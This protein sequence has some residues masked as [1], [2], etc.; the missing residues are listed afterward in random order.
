MRVVPNCYPSLC[1]KDG[2]TGWAETH[3][4]GGVDALSCQRIDVAGGI[5]DD[6]QV[7]IKRCRQPLAPEPQRCRLH[8]LNPAECVRM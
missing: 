1:G 7:V 2:W 5:S 8:P 3:H 4:D 6:E